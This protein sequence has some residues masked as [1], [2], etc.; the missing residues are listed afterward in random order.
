M[1]VTSATARPIARLRR[2][3]RRLDR[4]RRGVAMVEA[5][6][7]LPFFLGFGLWGI[8]LANYSLTT[9]KVGQLAVH[10]ADNASR[11]GDVSTIDNRKITEGDIDDLLLGAALQAGQR[12]NIYEKGRV[13]VSSLE[14]DPSNRQYIHWQRC[15]GKKTV[16]SSYGVQG[17]VLP[18]GM[19]PTGREVIALPGEAV[20]FVEFQ[21]DYQPLVSSK[22][23]ASTAIKSIASFTVRNSRDLSQIYQADPSAPAPVYTC[24]TYTNAFANQLF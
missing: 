12:M 1:P 15:M 2:H 10:L 18:N 7:I 6:L 19:G 14:V 24:G 13:I 17:A 9:M 3:L 20:I 5:A 11:I 8:E 22:L 16:T 23:I 4:D 21:Y